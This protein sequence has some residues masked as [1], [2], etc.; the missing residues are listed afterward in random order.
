MTKFPRQKWLLLL[1]AILLVT[2]IITLSFYWSMK[3]ADRPRNN[4]GGDR[5][6]RMGQFM[7]NELKL[8]KEQETIYW[9]LRDTM[10]SRQKPLMDSIRNTKKRFFDLLKEPAPQDSVLQAKA[11][12]IGALQKQLDLITFQHFQ[13]VRALC[14]PEQ[15]LKFDTVIKEIV[16]RMTGAWRNPG[17]QGA[18]KDSAAVKK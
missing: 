8:D 4:D 18:S 1:V 5:Q 11:D 3:P 7:V 17:K 13:Q 10:M 16:N 14:K 15:V 6:K 9:Q 2:N 12:E